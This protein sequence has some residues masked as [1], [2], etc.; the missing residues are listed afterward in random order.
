MRVGAGDGPAA[1]GGSWWAWLREFRADQAGLAAG[2][3]LHGTVVPP[4]PC[5]LRLDVRLQRCDRPRT[6]E[7]AVDGDLRGQAV[8]RLA[9][10]GGGTRVAVAWSLEM[11]S[12]PLRLAAR[13]A[14]PVMR[15][16][17][18][19]V[20]AMAVSGF[21]RRALPAAAA[22]PPGSDGRQIPR[23]L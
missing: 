5:R 1:C 11:R 20:V 13:A 17:H 2:N 8:L 10:A 12:V 9:D 7:A 18:D 14:D 16:G 23:P 3:V 15:W 21:R 19:R 6:V 22:G 4:V